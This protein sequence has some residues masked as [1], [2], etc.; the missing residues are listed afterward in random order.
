MLV[1][2]L[3]SIAV[4]W[5]GGKLVGS[6]AM[7]VGALTAYL[8]YLLQILM[9]VMM[10]T[11]MFVM[12]PRAEVWAGGVVGVLVPRPGGRAPPTWASETARG[13]LELR[14]AE[15]RYPGAQQPVL[16]DI[17]L[18]AE[19]G[20]VTAIIGGTGSG[21]TTLISLIPRLFDVTDGAVLVDGVNVRDLGLK[22]L[23]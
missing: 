13:R 7:A 15:F 20:Q 22:M 11:F 16:C 10:A 23:S 8:T 19:P 4:L 2:N 18:V 14:Q 5:F 17:N 12:V 3:S 6:G 1:L 9:S 21:K